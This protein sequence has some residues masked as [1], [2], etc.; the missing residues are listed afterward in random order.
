MMVVKSDCEF[1]YVTETHNIIKGQGYNRACYSFIFYYI[2][3]KK[4]SET[5]SHFKVQFTRNEAK[6]TQPMIV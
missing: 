6:N 3:Y 4:M 1:Y 5:V 2:L